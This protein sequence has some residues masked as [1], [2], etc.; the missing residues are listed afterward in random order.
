M[1]AGGPTRCARAATAALL[2]AALVLLALSGTVQAQELPDG[3]AVP[4]EARRRVAVLPLELPL[5][6]DLSARLDERG[7]QDGSGASVTPPDSQLVERAILGHLARHPY[8]E[9]VP[10][11]K[12]RDELRELR[13]VAVS[14]EKARQR[15]GYGQQHFFGFDLDAAV[16]E[17]EAARGHFEE[18]FGEVLEPSGYA[19]ALQYL[20]FS[21]LDRSAE[22]G[23]GRA[24]TTDL[25]AA[26]EAMR[27]MV[28]VAPYIVLDRGRQPV[29]RVELFLEARRSLLASRALRRPE[30]ERARQLAALLEVDVLIFARLVE[31]EAGGGW[32]VELDIFD[33]ALDD[34]ADVDGEEDVLPSGVDREVAAARIDARMSRFTSCIEPGQVVVDKGPGAAGRVYLDVGFVYFVFLESPTRTPFD[35]MGATVALTYMFTDYLSAAVRFAVAVSGEDRKRDLQASF[36]TFRVDLTLGLSVPLRWVRPVLELGIEVAKPTPF[37]TTRDIDCKTHGRNDL[38]CH[39]SEVLDY[40][41]ELLGGLY[42]SLG[43]NVN[44][45]LEPLY[46]TALTHFA[47]YVVPLEGGKELNFPVGFDLG[48]QYRF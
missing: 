14:L 18:G 4:A 28:R 21:L 19:D 8:V 12:V 7:A 48:L 42:A 46:L 36:N 40:D 34:F 44:L 11:S 13:N 45:G 23:S 41:V 1:P 25:V 38:G 6:L 39:P 26:R 30:L 15:L 10:A 17:L 33:V 2:Y 16:A 47:F 31:L 20:A 35:N 5:F 32:R 43:A 9:L 3:V 24:A 22:R 27:E 29:E 37:W